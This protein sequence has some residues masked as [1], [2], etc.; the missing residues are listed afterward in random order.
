M[1][2]MRH[3]RSKAELHPCHQCAR[4]DHA[5]GPSPECDDGLGAPTIGGLG[6]SDHI[7]DPSEGND[8]HR[9][10]GVLVDQDSEEQG[11]VRLCQAERL[12]EEC[13]VL[14]NSTRSCGDPLGGR[15]R[16]LRADQQG[17]LRAE[18]EEGVAAV[19]KSDSE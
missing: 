2:G 3:L 8:H 14:G 12:G 13:N 19:S 11:K 7:H 16:Q 18:E 10:Q 9:G 1:D 5:R 17:G 4:T 15:R 6:A